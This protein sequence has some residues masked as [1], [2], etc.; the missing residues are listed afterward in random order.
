M[1]SAEWEQSGETAAQESI[2]EQKINDIA[3]NR[4]AVID[5]ITACAASTMAGFQAKAKVIKSILPG[6]VD[7]FNL[8]N[9]S[10]EIR[11]VMSL[12]NDLAKG[13]TV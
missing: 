12:M 5:Q 7:A 2:I 3:N 6:S 8:T 13:C 9:D 11:L 4:Y 10:E 1:F